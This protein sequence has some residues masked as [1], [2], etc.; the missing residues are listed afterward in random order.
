MAYIRA[1]Y[2]PTGELRIP[3]L[4]YHEIGDGATSARLQGAYQETVHAAGRDE[5]LR[6][7]WVRRA[8]HCTFSLGE[9]VAA[10]QALEER[11]DTGA[12]D[13]ARP[14]QPP[15][16]VV[17]PDFGRFTDHRVGPRSAPL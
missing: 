4:S 14:A 5:L 12:A 1:N 2:A 3:V 11:I 13:L 15:R 17:A 8:G 6:T 16:H 7:A 10:L 9:H